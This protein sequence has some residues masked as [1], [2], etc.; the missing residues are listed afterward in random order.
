MNRRS[1][2][3]A[4]AGLAAAGLSGLM[5]KI[6]ARPPRQLDGLGVDH[7]EALRLLDA[8]RKA[9]RER[10]LE[11]APPAAVVRMNTRAIELFAHLVRTGP[12]DFRG[13]GPL[14]CAGML[15]VLAEK[16]ETED[17]WAFELRGLDS[18]SLFAIGACQRAGLEPPGWG[19]WCYAGSRVLNEP[20]EWWGPE[21]VV[22]LDD[23]GWPFSAR[24]YDPVDKPG[25]RVGSALLR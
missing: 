10:W 5:H 18:D 19:G 1:F 2:I 24:L 6:P 7:E 13:G 20:G 4:V 14:R 8:L 11:A 21:L 3:G 25:K 15:V 17:G 22:Y 16:L 9:R 23:D 12:D